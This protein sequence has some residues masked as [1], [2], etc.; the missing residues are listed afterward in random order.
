MAGSDYVTQVLKKDLGKLQK[1]LITV[2][3][4]CESN[5]ASEL[6]DLHSEMSAKHKSLS[7]TEFCTW[8]EKAAIKEKALIKH[9][10]DLSNGKDQKNWDKRLEIETNISDLNNAIWRLSR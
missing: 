10:S 2:V 4:R 8:L 1:Q 3:A 6:C 7:N 9:Q 5:P